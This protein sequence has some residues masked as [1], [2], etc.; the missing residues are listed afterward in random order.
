MSLVFPLQSVRREVRFAAEPLRRAA[1]LT[2]S[3]RPG[4][5]ATRHVDLPGRVRVE[6]PRQLLIR[7]IGHLEQSDW[8][9]LFTVGMA[10][11]AIAVLGVLGIGLASLGPRGSAASPPAAATSSSQAFQSLAAPSPVPA[12][13]PEPTAA[14]TPP[15]PA[16][17]LSTVDAGGPGAGARLRSQPRLDSSIV[18]RIVHGTQV[19]E[20]GPEASDGQRTWRQVK[21]PSGAIG[22]MDASLLRRTSR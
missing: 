14:P 20:V 12:V 11:A 17:V 5:E 1:R 10:I 2:R 18:E 8:A 6:S 21:S 3:R 4:F 16:Q 7:A 22:W 19:T 15:P 9:I 13:A